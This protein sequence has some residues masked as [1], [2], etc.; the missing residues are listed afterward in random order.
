LGIRTDC[1]PRQAPFEN[2]RGI[3]AQTETM[4]RQI[5]NQGIKPNGKE[6][7][8][9]VELNNFS[10]SLGITLSYARSTKRIVKD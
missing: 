7:Q 5:F 4:P 3:K 2:A 6:N 10:G 1:P 8:T 9:T